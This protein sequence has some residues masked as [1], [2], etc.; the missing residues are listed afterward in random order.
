MRDIELTFLHRCEF[1][2]WPSP[3]TLLESE[4]LIPATFVV[5]STLQ[6]ANALARRKDKSIAPAYFWEESYLEMIS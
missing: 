2:E 5:F 4:E 3:D 6:D 1:G